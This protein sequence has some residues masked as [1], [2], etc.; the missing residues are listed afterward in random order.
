MSNIFLANDQYL[1]FQRMDPHIV[2]LH[3]IVNN[4]LLPWELVLRLILINDFDIIN[5]ADSE[6]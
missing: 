6:T 5:V 3:A 4:C 2:L 1:H